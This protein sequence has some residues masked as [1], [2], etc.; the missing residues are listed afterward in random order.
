MKVSIASYS[1]HGL[2]GAGMMDI[3]GYLE[4]VKYRYNLDAA[5]IWAGTIGTLDPDRITQ[6]K[7]AL[8][9]RELVLANYHVDGVHVWEDDPDKREANY[10]G[11]LAHLQAAAFLGAQTV[12]IDL[13]GS[14]DDLTDEQIAFAGDRYR[15]YAEFGAAHGFTVGP[16]THWGPSLNPQ[17]Q[18]RV[19]E[20]VNHPAYGVLLHIS[21]FIDGHEDEGDCLVAPW[22]NHTHVDARVTRTCLAE[23]MRLL[24]D[25]GYTG[26]WGVEHHSAQ[27][28]YFEVACQL[29]EV[30]R[31]LHQI[32]TAEVS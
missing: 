19:Y 3:F 7:Q 23:K 8:T 20:A 6:V 25:A 27:N 29:A 12:R 18:K 11:A 5:D 4:T 1:F 22:A 26:Y 24:L 15:E 9:E 16:E 21:H 10:R 13:G 2:I 28:E 32:E 31:T 30:Q 14:G 17:V